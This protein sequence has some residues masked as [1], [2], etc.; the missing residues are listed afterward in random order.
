MAF[1]GAAAVSD[2]SACAGWP[3]SGI[4]SADC[5]IR[6]QHLDHRHRPSR[7]SPSDGPSRSRCSLSGPSW[8]QPS[9][10]CLLRFRR[11]AGA[12]RQPAAVPLADR[13]GKAG[14]A[15]ADAGG[16]WCYPA[17]RDEAP[18]GQRYPHLDQGDPAAPDVDR[19][20]GR[21]SPRGGRAAFRLG[22][23]EPADPGR[24]EG[25]PG[26]RPPGGDRD[27]RPR[28]LYAGA[29]EGPRRR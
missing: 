9:R 6:D 11:D 2:A 8:S 5:P 3:N 7:T 15:F 23:L 24:A 19:R 12:R 14:E 22:A 27:R 10:N 4:S 25:P 13:G 17:S 18:V 21:G 26:C 1:D 28:P 20:P 29:A 16:P